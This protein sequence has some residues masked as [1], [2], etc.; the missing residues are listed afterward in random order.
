MQRQVQT[1][2]VVEDEQAIITLLE[3]NLEK[4]GFR[5]LSAQNGQKAQDLLAEEKVDVMLL[6]WML[7]QMSGVDLCHKLRQAPET[8]QMPILMVT[9]RG[10]EHDRVKGLDTGADD[11]ITKPFSPKEVI[12]RVRA[13]LRRTPDM[14]EDNLLRQ[15][16]I[17]MDL[18]GIRVTRDGAEVH[19]G[20]TEFRL[21]RYLM[22][23]PGRVLSR[24]QLLGKIWGENVHVE[25]RTVDVHIR[26]LRKALAVN[27]H[28]SDV[29]RTVRAAGYALEAE[30]EA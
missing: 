21:L 8:S 22:E 5:V 7:P 12:A 14:P 15:Q 26:R 29:I 18:S 25:P 24:E 20:P 1:V 4:A 13:V 9:A 2:L 16:D 17:E 6:D 27:D 23:N 3:Y 30:D 28:V 11:Y 10:E 19:L